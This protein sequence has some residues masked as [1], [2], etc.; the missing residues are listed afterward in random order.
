MKGLF[1]K[2]SLCRKKNGVLLGA[3]KGIGAAYARDYA[4]QCH[5][6]SFI[7]IDKEAGLRLKRD[8]EQE[9]RI[10]VFFFHGDVY[11]E[12]DMDIFC[13]AVKEQFGKVDL[14]FNGFRNCPY[15]FMTKEM[16]ASGAVLEYIGA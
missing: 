4:K 13:K 8:L 14:L 2:K 5:T 1:K 6:I 9:Y 3:A 10:H 7:D 16:L 12:S 11:D 15:L